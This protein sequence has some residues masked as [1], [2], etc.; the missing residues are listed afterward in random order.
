MKK[1]DIAIWISVKVPENIQRFIVEKGSVAIDGVSLTIASVEKESFKVSVIPH[2]GEN[3][4]LLTK[5]AG[6]IVNIENDIRQNI[7]VDELD[8]AEHLLKKGYI[9]A[10]GSIAGVVLENHLKTICKSIP[11]ITLRGDETLSQYNAHLKSIL[12]N[13]L[14]GKVDAISRI[15]NLCDHAKEETPTKA[16]VLLLINETRNLLKEIS[17]FSY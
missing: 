9:R 8:S 4:I 17:S 13:I 11:S 16:D 6:D 7:Y 10:A 5:K 14:W 2:T 15:R 1:D 12:G 3:T